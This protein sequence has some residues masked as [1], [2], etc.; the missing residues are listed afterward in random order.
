MADVSESEDSTFLK[1]YYQNVGREN[2][3]LAQE[4]EKANLSLVQ[5]AA[6]I[7]PLEHSIASAPSIGNAAVD[8]WL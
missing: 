1:V 7:A 6:Q 4:L 2:V 5:R 8:S 3:M